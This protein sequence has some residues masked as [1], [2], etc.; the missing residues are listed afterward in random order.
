MSILTIH[1]GDQVVVKSATG[2]LARRAVTGPIR[3]EDFMVIRLA[4]EDE[5]LSAL[6]EGREPR[7]VPWPAEDVRPA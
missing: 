3:G 5:Y 6:A 2:E 7:S 4:T 1:Q